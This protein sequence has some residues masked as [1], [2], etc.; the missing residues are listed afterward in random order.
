MPQNP[1]SL[2]RDWAGPTLKTLATQHGGAVCNLSWPEGAGWPN[3]IRQTPHLP[4]C[5]GLAWM[6]KDSPFEGIELER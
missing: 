6:F 4:G 5:A 2:S 3:V 1:R